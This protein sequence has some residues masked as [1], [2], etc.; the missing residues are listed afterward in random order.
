M[1]RQAC[2]N[3]VGIARM[4][5]AVCQYEVSQ[6]LLKPL[7]P[8][9]SVKIGNLMA[10]FPSRRM[11]SLPVRTFLDTMETTVQQLPPT[12]SLESLETAWSSTRFVAPAQHIVT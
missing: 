4:P 7:F 9:W 11:L 10:I 8:D 2:L 1:A 3:G 5:S 6:G 12:Y